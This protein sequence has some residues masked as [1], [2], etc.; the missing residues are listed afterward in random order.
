MIKEDV[1]LGGCVY[2]FCDNEAHYTCDNCQENCCKEHMTNNN[3]CNE[4][5][6]QTKR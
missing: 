5:G 6:A 1:Y 2:V 4:C 3:L